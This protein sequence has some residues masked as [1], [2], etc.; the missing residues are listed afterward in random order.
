MIFSLSVSSCAFF[1]I[2]LII[3]GY[4]GIL[5]IMIYQI[6][7]NAVDVLLVLFSWFGTIASTVMGIVSQ[8]RACATFFLIYEPT[9]WLKGD[10]LH[11]TWGNTYFSGWVV[12]YT[13]FDLKS[14]KKYLL[15][16]IFFEL[17]A[18]PFQW[19]SCFAHDYKAYLSMKIST[20]IISFSLILFSN[21]SRIV[22]ETETE[23]LKQ[24]KTILNI[25]LP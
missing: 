4:S 21:Y 19:F 1:V 9:G 18:A 10:I 23:K 15:P 20:C 5:D 7:W 24:G 16:L 25:I 3:R 12:R 8:P 2:L 14:S 22:D 13:V 17:R 11:I 6:V